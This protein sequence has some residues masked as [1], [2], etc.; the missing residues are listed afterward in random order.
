M[1]D[2]KTERA[3]RKAAEV[4]DAVALQSAQAEKKTKET[5]KAVEKSKIGKH[6][7]T[8]LDSATF[9]DVIKMT[10]FLNAIMTI[11]F[12]CIVNSAA[13]DVENAIKRTALNICNYIILIFGLGGIVVDSIFFFG[14]L[15]ALLKIFYLIKFVKFLGMVLFLFATFRGIGWFMM[16]SEWLYTICCGLLDLFFMYYLTLYEERVASDDY[17]ENGMLKADRMNNEE[18]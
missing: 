11:G 10:L 17:D 14:Q 4:R 2:S 18:P 6:I 9:K 3:K 7:P 13:T 12:Y 15:F 1:A 8:S 5:I 16:A